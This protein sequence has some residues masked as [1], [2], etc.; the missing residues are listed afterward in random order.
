MVGF[1]GGHRTSGERSFSQF[2][3]GEPF[4]FW[5]ETRC[6]FEGVKMVSTLKFCLD[7]RSAGDFED[8]TVFAKKEKTLTIRR[9]NPV[10]LP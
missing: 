2:I 10:D 6:S 9:S 1:V 4:F 7:T 3:L 8:R 5:Q